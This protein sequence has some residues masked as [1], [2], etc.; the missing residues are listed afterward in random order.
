MADVPVNLLETGGRLTLPGSAPP[1]TTA[2]PVTGPVTADVPKA[3]RA[4]KA[5][6]KPAEAPAD[7]AHDGDKPCRYCGWRQ[8]VDPVEPGPEDAQNFRRAVFSGVPFEKTATLFA[9]T[10]VTLRDLTYA[11]E[12]EAQAYVLKC[13]ETAPYMTHLEAQEKLTEARLG[14][15]VVAGSTG[16]RVYKPDPALT[17]PAER[18]AAIAAWC[19]TDTVYRALRWEYTRF[20]AVL[21]M[22]MTRAHDR[23]FF[24]ATG[25]GG[26]SPASPPST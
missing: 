26:V 19:G 7:H 6:G 12:Q 11:E 1:R 20:H 22:L 15:A 2:P 8:S 3:E 14:H 23:S 9:A 16:G 25:P 10:T 18:H 4:E 21:H 5:D 24:A 13:A 17:T